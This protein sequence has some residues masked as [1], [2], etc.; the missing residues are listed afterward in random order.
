MSESSRCKTPGEE[1]EEKGAL[2][3]AAVPE[4]RSPS[5]P[6]G[7]DACWPRRL[8]SSLVYPRGSHAG[9][10]GLNTVCAFVVSW[11]GKAQDSMSTNFKTGMINHVSQGTWVPL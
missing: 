10:Y 4:P 8:E 6:G 5:M 9:I 11:A 7:K 2:R 3:V 1:Q